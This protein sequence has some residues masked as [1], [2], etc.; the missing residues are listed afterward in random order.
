MD[1]KLCNQ[2]SLIRINPWKP[3][4]GGFF[5]LKVPMFEALKRVL[6]KPSA[7]V[8]ALESLE[9]AERSYLNSKASAEYH[10]KMSE[11]YLIVIDRLTKYLDRKA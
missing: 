2:H 10:Q 1:R 3:P 7:G 9:E 6:K 5:I 8:I 4:S 11:Y